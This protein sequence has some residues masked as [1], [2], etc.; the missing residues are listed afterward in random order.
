MNSHGTKS[1]L[2]LKHN[3]V[4]V[5]AILFVYAIPAIIFTIDTMISH[6]TNST[7]KDLS[8]VIA[9]VAF[10]CVAMW[11]LVEEKIPFDTIGLTL[12]GIKEAVLLALVGWGIVVLAGYLVI[13]IN[14][15]DPGGLFYKSAPYILQY[16]VFVG[17]TEELL[18]RGYILTR[19]IKFWAAR[20]KVLGQILAVVVASF[21]FATAH[22][23]QRMYQVAR[24]DMTLAGVLASVVLLS[25]VGI[26]FSY[27]F[28]RTKN[29][30][31]VGLI[32]GA[33]IVPLIG[34][35]EDAFLPVIIIA[36]LYIESFLILKR[37]RLQRNL[38]KVR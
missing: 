6:G 29:I 15:R 14:N 38:S 25:I 3:R 16:W 37:G 24:G 12:T 35:G 10:F 20:N 31:L 30:I 5:I 4:F 27:L 33:V 36:I 23:P 1:E 21:L 19:L 28:L 8:V 2:P 17:V 11:G 18:F 22:I 32:H 34:V 13:V 9:G 7:W 26:V